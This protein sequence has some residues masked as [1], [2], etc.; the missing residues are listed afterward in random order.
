[1]ENLDV[2]VKE[3]M[4]SICKYFNKEYDIIREYIDNNK[5]S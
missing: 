3:S 5:N 1:M 2:I 4:K